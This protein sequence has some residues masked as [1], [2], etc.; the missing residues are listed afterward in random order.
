MAM[1]IRMV[2]TTMMMMISNTEIDFYEQY[3]CLLFV[4]SSRE[5]SLL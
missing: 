1:M 5:L 3:K 4:C 2:M